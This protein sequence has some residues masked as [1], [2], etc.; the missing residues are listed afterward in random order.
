MSALVSPWA[1]SLDRD[2]PLPEY[3][4]P[5][6]ARGKWLNLNGPWDYAIRPVGEA[7]AAY[8]G[9]IVVPFPI[10]SVLSGVQRTLGADDVL[11]YR[12]SFEPPAS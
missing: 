10:E 2:R 5:S 3:P 1:S 4:R 11:W 8:D 6:L 9:S 12:R 7:P